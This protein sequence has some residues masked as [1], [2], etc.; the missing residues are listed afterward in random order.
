MWAEKVSE[1]IAQM[2]C[3]E[4][5][6]WAMYMWEKTIDWLIKTMSCEVWLKTVYVRKDDWLIDKNNELWSVTKDCKGEKRRLIDWSRQWVVKCDSRQYMWQKGGWLIDQKLWMMI[7]IV[8]DATW[9]SVWH[10]SLIKILSYRQ[11]VNIRFDRGI[12]LIYL[13]F[14][15]Q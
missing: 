8:W 2:I 1:M 14:R 6:H 13:N 7:N 9:D 12:H 11:L 15:I 10:H 3:C 5:W 4:L